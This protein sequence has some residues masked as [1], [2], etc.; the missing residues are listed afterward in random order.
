MP[1][2]PG[3]GAEAG[4]ALVSAFWW[5]TIGYGF[6]S[7]LAYGTRMA[8]FMQV[9]SPKVAATQFTAYMAF[10]N[11]AISYSAAWQGSAVERLGYPLTLSLDAIAGIACIS[12]LPFLT[13]SPADDTR[14]PAPAEVS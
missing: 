11:L 5:A 3:T 2:D 6:F 12:I 10:S 14:A 4:A 1:V 9:C 13:P 7:G 8:I